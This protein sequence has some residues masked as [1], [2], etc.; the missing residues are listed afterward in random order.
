MGFDSK[1]LLTSAAVAGPA[2]GQWVNLAPFTAWSIYVQNLEI[3]GEV[4]VY[5][6]NSKVYPG[7]LVDNVPVDTGALIMTIN[8]TGNT[9]A[10]GLMP[11]VWIQVVKTPGI[12]PAVTNV[13]IAG[14]AY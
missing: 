14:P 5:A 4:Q 13:V 10:L 1:V 3:G 11:A 8:G 2:I 9:I 12:A 7:T 6:S